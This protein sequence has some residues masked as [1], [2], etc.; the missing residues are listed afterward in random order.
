MNRQGLGV[1]DRA[2]LIDR[3]ADNVHDASQR[4]STYRHRDWPTLV[5]RLHTAHHAVRSLHRDT[6]YASFAQVLL[7]FQ[8]DIDRRRHLESVADHS[9]GLIDRWDTGRRKLHVD[10]W[11]GN[12]NNM[13]NIFWHKNFQTFI[14]N[15]A[16]STQH[17]VLRFLC[18]TKQDRFVAECRV[19]NADCCPTAPLPR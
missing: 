6:A 17:S 10:C 5:K 16:F 13:S 2:Q 8:Y 18:R 3:L 1:L 19:L 9:Q 7:D 11:T 14:K 4:T 12:L 15:L